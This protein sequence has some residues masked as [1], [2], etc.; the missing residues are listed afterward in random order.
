MECAV[1][2]KRVSELY[3]NGWSYFC[4]NV[5]LRNIEDMEY[6]QLNV[7]VLNDLA[8]VIRKALENE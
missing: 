7:K 2:T 4:I 1:L 5:L 3:A 6:L 8:S